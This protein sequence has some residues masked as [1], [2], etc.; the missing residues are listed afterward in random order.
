[1]STKKLPSINFED[2]ITRELSPLIGEDHLFSDDRF[3]RTWNWTYSAPVTE[4]FD[5]DFLD[6]LAEALRKLLPEETQKKV[7]LY[8]EPCSNAGFEHKERQPFETPKK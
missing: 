7:N 5:K 1:M 8:G 3:V 2:E 4:I 6:N